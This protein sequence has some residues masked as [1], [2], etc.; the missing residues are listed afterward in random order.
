MPAAELELWYRQPA[1]D[2]EKEALPLG[3]G[4]LGALLLGAPDKQ[5][6]HLNESSVWTGGVKAPVDSKARRDA[7]QRGRELLEAGQAVEAEALLNKD[8]M[9]PEDHGRYQPLGQLHIDQAVSAVTGYERHLDLRDGVHLERYQAGAHRFEREAFCSRPAGVFAMRVSA[10]DAGSLDLTLA[11]SREDNASVEAQGAEIHLKG[12]AGDAGKP[13]GTRFDVVL[14]VLPQGGALSVSGNALALQ[15]ADAVTLLLA[16]HTDY[17]AA[18]PGKPL[19]RDNA[20][21]CRADLDAAAKQGYTALLEAQRAEHRALA[22]RVQLELEAPVSKLPT[23]ARLAAYQAGAEDP[24]L[25]ALYFAYGRYLLMASSIGG[26]LPANLQGLWSPLP[27]PAWNSDYHLNINLQMNYWPAENLG[28]GEAQEPLIHFLLACRPQQRKLAKALGCKG[29]AAGHTT[30]AWAHAELT[31]QTLWGMWVMGAAWASLQAA[32]HWRYS[33]DPAF[34][35]DEAWPLLSENAEFALDW[36]RPEKGTGLLISGPTISPE[37]AY[38]LT[39]GAKAEVSLGPAMDQAIVEQLFHE[40]EDAAAALGKQDDPLV[41]RVR[42]AKAKL[43]PAQ[44][45]PDGRLLEW[46]QPYEEAEPGHRHV[47]HLFA[48][49]PGDAFARS[50]DAKWLEAARKTLDS[51]LAH[52]GG[53]TGWSRAWLLNFFARLGDSDQT[54]EQLR[55]LLTKSTYPNLWD[56]HPPFQIDGN[57]GA[58]AGLGECLLQSQAGELALLPALPSGWETGSVR[59]LRA[60]GG[61]AVD[62]EWVLGGLNRASLTARTD[63]ERVVRC[64]KPKTVTV[65]G[66]AVE[67]PWSEGRLHLTLTAGTTAVLEW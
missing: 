62:L 22:D 43:A 60:R 28:L 25:E 46:R 53:G 12:Q 64:D 1:A 33:Q 13:S 61:T 47:S 11:L 2:W 66:E 35:R 3:N 38:K 37:N 50:G 58:A 40:V 15:G 65:D 26:E 10:K 8:F 49:H 55:Q 48:L 59:G 24:G 54:Q 20:A 7:L 5:L 34:L 32:E 36:L 41:K 30:D 6:I 17:N 9:Q 44:I 45:G 42:E 27:W 52:G 16:A 29:L 18:E 21:L 57:F 63:G 19:G 23:D 4:R 51:R 39:T 31:G 14:R 56:A 67:A